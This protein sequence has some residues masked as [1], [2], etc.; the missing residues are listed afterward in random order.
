[1]NEAERLELEAR[2]MAG[3]EEQIANM[4]DEE[5][6]ALVQSQ[7]ELGEVVSRALAQA[8]EVMA[9]LAGLRLGKEGDE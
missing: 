6:A 8:R 4:S 3:F 2:L 1:M 5:L 9:S 7:L